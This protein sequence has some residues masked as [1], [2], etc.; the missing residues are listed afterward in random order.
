MPCRYSSWDD[1]FPATGKRTANLVRDIL[2]WVSVRLCD[3]NDLRITC[4][5]GF[6]RPS[7]AGQMGD[8]QRITCFWREDPDS[9]CVKAVAESDHEYPDCAL[10]WASTASTVCSAAITCSTHEHAG[11]KNGICVNTDNQFTAKRRKPRWDP[12]IT[13]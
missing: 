4:L 7:I 5:R 12:R 3:E 1:C 10:S 13:D 2:N 9:K 8:H 11:E 6:T